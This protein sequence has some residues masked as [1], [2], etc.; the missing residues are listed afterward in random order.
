MAKINPFVR[1]NDGKCREAMSFYK[2][3]FGGKVELMTVKDSPMVKDMPKEKHGLIMH[4]ILTVKNQVILIG[5]DMMRD[6]AVVGDNVGISLDCES[7]KELKTIFAKLEK[8]GDVFMAPEEQFW[9]GV[10]GVVTDKYG[11]EWMM[12]FQKKPMKA[13]K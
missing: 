4:G 11:V 6:R 3:C 10:F 7:E 12:N 13:K 8:G 9:G 5:M 1:F 2:N